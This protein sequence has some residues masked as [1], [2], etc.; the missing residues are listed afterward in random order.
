[1]KLTITDHE[2]LYAVEQLMLSL[3]AE[4]EGT[5]VS[6]LMRGKVWLTAVTEI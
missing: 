1:M 3:F 5:A 4:G 6:R 2:D